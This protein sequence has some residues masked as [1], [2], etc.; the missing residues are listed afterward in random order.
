MRKTPR[1][2]FGARVR[3]L[4]FDKGLNQEELADRIGVFRTYM[5]RIE[6]GA[7]NPTLDMIHALAS[8]LG[9]TPASLF[10]EATSSPPKVRSTA[11][12]SRGRVKK[13]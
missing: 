11:G 12:A 1:Q 2:A 9:V 4:R 5:S 6:T 8:A 3:Q 10:E 7:G 13:T